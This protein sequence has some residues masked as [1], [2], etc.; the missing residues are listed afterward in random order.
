MADVPRKL[1]YYWLLFPLFIVF[2]VTI[3]DARDPYF[4]TGVLL[5]FA[6]G[7]QTWNRTVL[8]TWLDFAVLALWL[9]ELLLLFTTFHCNTSQFQTLTVTVLYYW[10]LRSGCNR[11]RRSR[12][13]LFACSILLC[14]MSL[15]A[16]VSFSLFE[17][18][19]AK[20]GFEDLYDFRFLHNSLGYLGNVWGNLLLGF[21][22]IIALTAYL[23]RHS[24]AKCTAL[25][26]MTIPV[27]WDI[28][29]SFS[30]GVYMAFLLMLSA[31]LAFLWAADLSWKRKLSIGAVVL[32]ALT[33]MAL[34]HKNDVL[35]TARMVETVSQQRSIGG[36]INGA[37]AA[38]EVMRQHPVT[39]VGSGNFS[40]AANEYLFE[41][42]YTPFTS[43]PLGTLFQLPV[44][45][46]VAGTLLWLAIPGVMVWMLLKDRGRNI[47]TGIIFTTLGAIIFRETTFPALLDYAGM[48]IV[49]F[50]LIAAYQNSIR[51]PHYV[52]HI[53]GRIARWLVCAPAVV[54]AGILISNLNKEKREQANLNS[55]KAIAAGDLL[56]AETYL[57]KA[58]N[59]L[60]YRINRSALQWR[61]FRQTGNRRY[62]T[63][64]EQELRTAALQ[65]PMDVYLGYDLAI[66]LNAAGYKDSSRRMVRHLIER[67]PDNALYRATFFEMTWRDNLPETD[68]AENMARAIELAPDILDTPLWKTLRTQDS[69]LYNRIVAILQLRAEELCRAISGYSTVHQGYNRPENQQL[70]TNINCDGIKV[71]H[72]GKIMFIFNRRELSGILLNQAIEALPNLSKPWYYLGVMALEKGDTSEGRQYL[73]RSILL[74]AGD[75]LAQRRLSESMG[76]VYQ[77][78]ARHSQTAYPYRFLYRNA[79]VKFK[80]WYDA[81]PLSFEYIG[82]SE[83]KY[84]SYHK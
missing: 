6:I 32:G 3:S 13:Y 56:S 78:P 45:K 42:D 75:T 10:V 2:A 18:N 34:P 55:L 19:V 83:P 58:G 37:K 22:G 16:W 49:V 27:L 11:E 38:W 14:A 23:Y 20:A 36:R 51:K 31:F 29:R 8:L 62:L 80:T 26:L 84:P 69:V 77:P 35:R 52:C 25:L 57:E 41:N 50:T 9:Y 17:Q 44:E 30:R 7:L 24:K 70:S 21:L 46:G 39:G 65:N 64:A 66:V 79:R 82:T 12:S 71:A 47:G 63:Q 74:A 60:P 40:M 72:F 5:T 76:Q 67:F 53:Q 1:S 59:A 28:I 43:I 4:V 33:L 54:C 61:L 15:I 68:A 73:R 81:Q 48:Q